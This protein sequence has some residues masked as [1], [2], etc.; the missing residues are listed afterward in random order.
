MSQ[1]EEQ[2]P[3]REYLIREVNTIHGDSQR[4]D[5]L[6]MCRERGYCKWFRARKLDVA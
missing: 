3:Q 1:T 6:V 5:P 2:K 4:L